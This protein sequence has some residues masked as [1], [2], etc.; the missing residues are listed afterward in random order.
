MGSA[1]CDGTSCGVSCAAPTSAYGEATN[2]CVNTMSDDN[3]CGGCGVPCG[4]QHCV[5]GSCHPCQPGTN[6]G[7]GH[8]SV[9]ICHPGSQTCQPDGTW[10]TCSGNQE[11]LTRD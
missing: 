10:G 3:N 6:Q 8:A 1:S 4:T 5:N 9:G 7:C 2:T 11:P